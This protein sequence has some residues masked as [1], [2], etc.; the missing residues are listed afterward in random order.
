[1]EDKNI[2][3]AFPPRL[4]DLVQNNNPKND[5]EKN[6]LYVPTWRD[7]HSFN[8]SDHIN[9]NSFNK[10]LRRKRYVPNN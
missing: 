4:Q 3:R 8:F 9:L 10:F 6:I 5:N 7:D 1:M 2:F